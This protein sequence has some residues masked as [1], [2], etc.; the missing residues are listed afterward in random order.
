MSGCPHC[1]SP[2]LKGA[3]LPLIGSVL[4]F[5]LPHHRYA[6]AACKWV[7]WKHRLKRRT[8]GLGSGSKADAQSAERAMWSL[9]PAAGLAILVGALL[10]RSCDADRGPMQTDQPSV[11]AVHSRPAL[12]A[13]TTYARRRDQR[14]FDVDVAR[15]FQPR[16][17]RP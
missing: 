8:Q 13:E 15:G 12:Y 2:R 9:L 10:A 11:G 4:Q 1:G 17:T 6:C 7:G 14:G 5:L 3:P 16:E